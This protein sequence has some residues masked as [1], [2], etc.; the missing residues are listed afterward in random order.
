MDPDG[1]SAAR[2]HAGRLCETMAPWAGERQYYNFAENPGD[3]AT[4]YEADA[5]SRLC[6]IRSRV[7]PE[8]IFQANHQMAAA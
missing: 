4:Y 8:G 1:A 2:E 5:Y 3:C 7:D 6:Q